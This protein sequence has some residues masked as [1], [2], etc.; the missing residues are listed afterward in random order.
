[1]TVLAQRGGVRVV[2]FNKAGHTSIINSFL[3][4]RKKK[5]MRG[6]TPALLNTSDEASHIGGYRGDLTN[7]HE[8]PKPEIIV[9]FIRN[10]VRR[11]LSAYQHFMVRKITKSADGTQTFGRQSF[12]DLGFVIGMTFPQFC[13]HL[14]TVDLLVDAHLRPQVSDLAEAGALAECN[15]FIIAPLEKFDTIWPLVMSEL[16]VDCPLQ[17]AHMNA[18]KYHPD[19]FLHGDADDILK[20]LYSE[21]WNLWEVITHET[22]ETFSA[23]GHPLH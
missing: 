17:P 2:A 3:T 10:P 18:G 4:P 9:S 20:E 23:V 1:M 16:N 6:G 11:A 7:C 21:D 14:A 13:E 8:W 12:A 22:R 15:S 19:E 5:I